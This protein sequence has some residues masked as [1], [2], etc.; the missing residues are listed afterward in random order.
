[1]DSYSLPFGSADGT[2]TFNG[3]F[4]RGTVTL[5][6]YIP[7]GRRVTIAAQVRLGQVFHF[8]DDSRTYP[9]RL[10]FLGGADTMRGFYQDQLPPAD[11]VAAAPTTN[12]GIR[13]GDLMV[14]PRVEVRIPLV[15]PL[16]SVAFV[17]IG[18]IWVDPSSIYERRIPFSMR[19]NVGTGIR[20]NTPVGVPLALDVGFNP[21]PLTWEPT[22]V[23][24]FA[25][26]LF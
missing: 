25:V 4:L 20:W 21:T 9:D 17:D 16:D 10:F 2:T 18:N 13:G 1:V 14:N 23:P 3:H 19:V 15:G 26:G 6:G 22:V 12:P 11:V 24:Q 8:F 7:I 5:A